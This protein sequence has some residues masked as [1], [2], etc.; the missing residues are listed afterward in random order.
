M[1]K[2]NVLEY[3]GQEEKADPLRELL[4]K[5]SEELIYRAVEAELQELLSSYSERRME[6]SKAAVVR[7]G[8]H[9]ERELQTGVGPVTVRIPKV[10][11]RAGKAVTFRSA[12]VPP[13]VRKTKSL[14]AALPWLYLK[15]I[16]TGEMR[17]ALKVLVGPNATGLS[18]SVVSRLKKVWAKEYGDWCETP[19][20]KD[21]W[22][23]VWADGVYSGLRAEQTKLCSLVVI[24][25]NERG[26]KRL[27]AIEDGVRESTQSWR[28]VLLKLKSR[29]MN[30]PA[31]AIGD[32]AM[33]FSGQ[34]LRKCILR[35][36][37]SGAGCTRP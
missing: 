12:L 9:P 1:R 31:L 32:G 36:D 7:N 37:S 6:G 35:A 18:P 8:Y 3:E 24:G 13:Y 16:S 14:E 33:G 25:V 11:S 23:Y 34:P 29:G 26:Q 2:S 5:G 20:D 28:E 15:G 27:L 17:E 10:R 21:R 30:V 4:R 22:V 19:L